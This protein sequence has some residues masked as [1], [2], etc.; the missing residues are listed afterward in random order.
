MRAKWQGGHAPRGRPRGAPRVAEQ[1]G[2]IRIVNR[3]ILSPIYAQPFPSF[4]PCGTMFPHDF[5]VLQETWQ[6]DERWM[7]AERPR[8][9]GPESTR[10]S[11]KHVR[12]KRK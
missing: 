4:N 8:S 11:S 6:R 3:G 9:R 5:F 10:S 12:K 1:R 2:H 7:Q